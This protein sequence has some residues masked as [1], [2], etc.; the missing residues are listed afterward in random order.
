MAASTID[1]DRGVTKKRHPKSGMDIYMYRDEPGVFRDAF[2]NPVDPRLA[3]SAGY[4]TD[5]LGKIKA[6]KER[7]AAAFA[8][9]EAELADENGLPKK[10]IVAERNGFKIVNLGLGRH[11]IEVPDGNTLNPTPVPK[12]EA[13]F[14]FDSVAGE[15]PKKAKKVSDK[16][17][18]PADKDQKTAS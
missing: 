8:A 13:E 17:P 10:Q 3:R 4:D 7:F 18:D 16:A 11:V 9:V 6:R 5:A 15:E 1:Y 14:I 2:G 12:E